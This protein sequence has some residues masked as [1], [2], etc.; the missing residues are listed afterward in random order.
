MA[1]AFVGYA[2]CWVAFAV[3]V[4]HAVDL[5]SFDYFGLACSLVVVGNH[6]DA[7]DLV[8]GSS[9]CGCH[10]GPFHLGYPGTELEITN[11]YR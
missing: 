7:F 9:H 1:P 5:A 8:D 4:D 6:L 10:E 2:C 3:V 11:I